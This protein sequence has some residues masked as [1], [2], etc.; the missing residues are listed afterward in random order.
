MVAFPGS[1]YDSAKVQA[2]ILLTNHNVKHRLHEL[3]EE[4]GMNEATADQALLY[5]MLQ[6]EDLP[7][8]MR[9]VS[10]YNK[11]MGRYAP[12]K[13]DPTIADPMRALMEL[14]LDKAD[15][16]N[17]SQRLHGTRN[18]TEAPTDAS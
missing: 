13:V 1:V 5:T 3:L 9:A 10:E 4:N 16:Q 14:V 18:E 2:S 17:R 8:K 15:A 12:E 6:V 7:S 11:L